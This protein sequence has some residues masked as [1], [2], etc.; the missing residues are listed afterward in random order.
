[1]IEQNDGYARNAFE[2]MNEICRKFYRR[3]RQGGG[4]WIYYC[5]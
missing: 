5:S 1:M 3:E 2:I 4:G